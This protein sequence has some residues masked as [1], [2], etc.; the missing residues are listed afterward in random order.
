MQRDMLLSR[1]EHW[2]KLLLGPPYLTY[3]VRKIHYMR[4]R[5]EDR[6]MQTNIVSSLVLPISPA[7]PPDNYPDSAKAKK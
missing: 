3:F 6:K 2:I 5:K 4:K 7:R 1:I